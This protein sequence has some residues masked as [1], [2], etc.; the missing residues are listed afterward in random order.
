MCLAA[1]Q[2]QS[3]ETYVSMTLVDKVIW[4]KL[5]VIAIWTL[6]NPSAP[7]FDMKAAIT[8]VSS[9]TVSDAAAGNAGGQDKGR[10]AEEGLSY[11]SIQK[12]HACA[13]NWS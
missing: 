2:N 11:T 10:R 6:Q 7:V 9:Q 3:N 4:V 13:R 8:E 5:A 12:V 1:K